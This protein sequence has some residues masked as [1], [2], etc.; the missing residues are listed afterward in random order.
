ME[1]TL[2]ENAAALA[3]TGAAVGAAMPHPLP[4]S[5]INRPLEGAFCAVIF[6]SAFAAGSGGFGGGLNLLA[7][8]AGGLGVALYLALAVAVVSIWNWARDPGHR[9][10]PALGVS[11][12]N[13]R[14]SSEASI[15][16]SS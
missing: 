11:D 4:P 8:A 15:S 2:I 13:R 12:A 10:R 5:R 9:G 14:G 7:I 16:K 6:G 3:V 1:L